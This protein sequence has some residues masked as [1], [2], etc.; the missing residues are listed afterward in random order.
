MD[1]KWVSWR[2]HSCTSNTGLV[3]TT[4]MDVVE[5]RVVKRE[6]MQMMMMDG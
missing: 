2:S 1:E 3:G 6:R 5:W 4:N